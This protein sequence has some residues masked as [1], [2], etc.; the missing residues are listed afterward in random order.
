MKFLK[1]AVVTSGFLLIMSCAK[2]GLD[3]AEIYQQRFAE[4]KANAGFIKDYQ[5][6]ELVA[7]AKNYQLLPI[8]SKPTINME[9]LAKAEEYA[10]VN[11]S[12][13]F[14][15]WQNGQL[16]AVNYFGETTEFT[17]LVSK[18]LSK[19]LSAIVVGRAIALGK[20]NSLEQ[21]VAD[22]IPQ[23]Q[24]TPKSKVLVKHLLN[25]QAGFLSQGYS[26]DPNHPWN[27]AY[28]SYEHENVLIHDYPLVDQPGSV[29]AYN[30]ATADMVALLIE[31]ATGER[32]ADFVNDEVFV[33]IGAKG[34][35][36]WV[37]REGGL[38]HS[39]CCMMFPA[40][41]YLRLALLLLNKGKVD[42]DQLIPEYYVKEMTMPSTHNE[43]FGLGV[44]LGQPYIERRGFSGKGGAGP[45][46][47]HSEPYLDEA[48]YL[49]DGNSSQVV[50]ILP[51]YNM[52]VLRL[53]SNPP[54]SPEWDNSFL[55]N[56]LIKGLK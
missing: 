39:G 5:P 9:A 34:G 19:P 53:G 44:W 2:H 11:N 4:I 23:W 28:L 50:Y 42:G 43:H 52:V 51:T 56:T 41:T 36:M 21:P 12:S 49:F 38:V 16:Q 47:L 48:L 6:T 13:V 1:R 14:M 27:K 17:P 15:V 24:G 40:E 55:P 10:K 25:M 7:G 30:N 54:K 32:Y 22:F 31:A 35:T 26:P 37:N 18:S 45:Q 33:K 29:Y 20:I 8:A 3:Y 46:V